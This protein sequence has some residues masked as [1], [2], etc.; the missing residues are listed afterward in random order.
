MV[1]FVEVLS[2]GGF[3]RVTA[4]G[5]A[6]IDAGPRTGA[7]A[8]CMQGIKRIV[9]ARAVTLSL[10]G[11]QDR[12]GFEQIARGH[13]FKIKAVVSSA[14]ALAAAV[15]PA[16]AETSFLVVNAEMDRTDFVTTAPGTQ[17]TGFVGESSNYSI[18]ANMN[19]IYIDWYDA[20]K[21]KIHHVIVAGERASDH[22]F[23]DYISRETKLP[24][25]RANVFANLDI[26]PASVPIMQKSES[27]KYA[28]AIG[29][30]LR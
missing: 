6:D 10:D 20:H 8:E 28:V 14:E 5:S 26:D 1:R 15:I 17:I 13:G 2:R 16:D 18:I 22:E 4:Y 9:G 11:V 30:A 19:R 25:H 7:F 27:Y 24:L 21:A 12:A 3:N 23:L 29:L